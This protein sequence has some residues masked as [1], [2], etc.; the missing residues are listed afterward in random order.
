MRRR[1]S[2]EERAEL[3]HRRE[4]LQRELRLV[5]A[6]LRG[7]DLLRLP[8]KIRESDRGGERRLDARWR[9]WTR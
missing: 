5:Q 7:D 8:D 4:Q 6:E 2:T 1:L 9:D 3:E